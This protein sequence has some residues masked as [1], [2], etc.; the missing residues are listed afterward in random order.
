MKHESIF[1][2][3][4]TPTIAREELFTVLN[5]KQISFT[6]RQQLG[7]VEL[8]ATE[9]PLDYQQ[10]GTILGGTVKAGPVIARTEQLDPALFVDL[11][12]E[13]QG[14]INF[15][16]S[17]YGEV[18][19]D[20]S[21]LCHAVKDAL[22]QKGIVSRFVLPQKNM[23][24]S[25]VAVSKQSV[26]EFLIVPQDGQFLI[27]KTA[28]VQDVD[29]WS[30]RDY[31][32]PNV[33]PKKGMLPLKVARMMVNLGIGVKNPHDCIVA[34]LFCGMGSILSEAVVLGCK[35]IVGC[36]ISQQSIDR[37]HANL[38]WLKK[39][40]ELSFESN[41]ICGD[42]THAREYFK[43]GQFDCIVTEPYLGPAYERGAVID[44]QKIVNTIK[45][46]QKLYIGSLREWYSLLADER[47]VVMVFP[48]IQVEDKGHTY[49]YTVKNV[50][51]RCEKLG[52]TLVAGP[53][54]YARPHAIVR[55]QIYVLKKTDLWHISNQAVQSKEIKIPLPSDSA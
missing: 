38:E 6:S 52:Y 9:S 50:I 13:S 23:I 27:A 3:G 39:H 22:K 5:R 51:D 1:I 35:Q 34:D 55:R 33:D 41:L 53:L 17:I 20:I 30:A 14:K 10:F 44:R 26:S 25:S 43:K 19:V 31:G 4:N 7:P 16:M 28:F 37:T 12:S 36:D 40:F 8:V 32:R 42:A 46:L 18:S 21:A 29:A 49:I 24:L 54:R 45:G 48:E 2:F 11:L 47:R 15:G